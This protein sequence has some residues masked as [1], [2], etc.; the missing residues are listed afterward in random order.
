MTIIRREIWQRY[1][2]PNGKSVLMKRNNTDILTHRY[3]LSL[4]VILYA[5][6]QIYQVTDVSFNQ[7]EMMS[8]GTKLQ[9]H[10]SLN[11][12]RHV[13]LANNLKLSDILITE[14]L[15]PKN[16]AINFLRL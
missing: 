8:L 2:Q 11:Q 3:G 12:D 1:L 13:M 15:L 4:V 5:L 7:W 14:E 16:I 10:S 6:V 9:Q